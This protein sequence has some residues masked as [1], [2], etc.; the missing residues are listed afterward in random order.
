MR[1]LNA[2]QPRLSAWLMPLPPSPVRCLMPQPRELDGQVPGSMGVRGGFLCDPC[3]RIVAATSLPL[4]RVRWHLALGW[5]RV[6]QR[7]CLSGL[8]ATVLDA[9]CARPIRMA[10]SPSRRLCELAA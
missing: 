2:L 1:C 3:V 5:Q 7:V 8:P 4:P 9:I 10:R 6:V